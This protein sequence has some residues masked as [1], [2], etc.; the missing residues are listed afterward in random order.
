M[1]PGHCASPP[2]IGIPID[3]GVG[4]N[5]WISRWKVLLIALEGAEAV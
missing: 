4:A 2:E 3:A 1:E 5:P